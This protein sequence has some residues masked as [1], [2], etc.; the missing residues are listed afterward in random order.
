MKE[1]IFVSFSKKWLFFYN[2]SYLHLK[3]WIF[4]ILKNVEPVLA[5][6]FTSTVKISA[7]WYLFL[8]FLYDSA[9]WRIFFIILKLHNGLKTGIKRT[10]NYWYASAV[11][12][13][14][15]S[16][17][18]CYLSLKHIKWQIFINFKFLSLFHNFIIFWKVHV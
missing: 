11:K 7:F 3:F 10:A 6:L 9:T 12:T 18:P 17:F 2:L 13:L 8:I 14:R 15:D 16:I 5:N 4:W 1:V